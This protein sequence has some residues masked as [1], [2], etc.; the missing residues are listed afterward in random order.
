ME[1]TRAS[2]G[3]PEVVASVADVVA[4]VPAVDGVPLEG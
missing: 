3:L 2:Y 1:E 4:A